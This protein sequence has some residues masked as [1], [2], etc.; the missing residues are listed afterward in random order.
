M[1]KIMKEIKLPNDKKVIVDDEDFDRLDK[2]TWHLDKYGYARTNITRD[3]GTKTTVS[4]H[5][6]LLGI[7]FGDKRKVDH[8]SGVISDN[9]KENLRICTNAQ[10]IRNQKKRSNNTSGLKGVSWNE[11][12]KSWVARIGFDNETIYIGSFNTAENAHAAYCAK[13]KELHGEFANF[14]ETR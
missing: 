5:R 9:R 6:M 10:N 14:G 8:R 3:D 11:K 12:N 7:R 1:G 2:F 13:A 4:M